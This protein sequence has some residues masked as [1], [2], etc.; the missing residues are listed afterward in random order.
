MPAVPFSAEREGCRK[1]IDHA[2]NHHPNTPV[3][4]YKNIQEVL[5]EP[6]EVKS[7]VDNNN[8][9]IVFIKQID[10]YNAVVIEVEKNADGRIIWHK[11]FYNQKK[12]PYANKGTR[13]YD[14]SPGGGVSPIIRTE[15]SAHDGSLSVLDDIA[16][17]QTNSE[18]AKN[19]LQDI[20]SENDI[21]V[22]TRIGEG[23]QVTYTPYDEALKRAKKAG[24]TKAQ[25]DRHIERV[26]DQ[27]KK[28]AER[29]AEKLN[30]GDRVNVVLDIVAPILMMYGL[31]DCLAANTAL[32]NN[33][34]IVSTAFIALLFFREAVGRR[35]WL[36]IALVTAASILLSL[37]GGSVG[38][39]FS[40]SK[41]SL[42]VLGAT[43][44]W[45]LENNCTRQIAD[46]DPIQI[47]TVKDFGSGLGALVIALAIGEGF[48]TGKH[49]AILL[50]L[51]FVAYGMSIYCYTYAQRI[52]GAAR[53]STYYALAPFIG[54]VLSF[55]LLGEALTPLFLLAAPVMAVGCWLAARNK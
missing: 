11:S 20:E 43:V 55:L 4:K 25:F 31:R 46:R 14:A 1:F 45:G 32:L 35:L 19:N 37:D 50:L 52:I 22:V 28:T 48:P 38:E 34:E 36:A 10:R 39:A 8:N 13:L 3:E 29:F 18:T 9:S 54:A 26:W 51:G 33:F 2:V 47:V 12:K 24:Y 6:D 30:L 44:C 15:E 21:S 16:K 5:N 40:F 27:R 17:V 53:T 41:G 42:L 49:I 23:P 7:I